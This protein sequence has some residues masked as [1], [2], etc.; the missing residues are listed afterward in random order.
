VHDFR[1][2][3][4]EGVMKTKPGLLG[5]R[6]AVWIGLADLGAYVSALLLASTG[7]LLK[8]GLPHGR[9]SGGVRHFG[10]P[11]E[12]WGLTR[13]GWGELHFWISMAFSAFIVLHL[14][15]HLPWIRIHFGR[16]HKPF[17]LTLAV[18]TLL[19]LL[20]LAGLLSL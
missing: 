17:T 13:S 2:S 6:R 7:L 1:V 12:V 19:A 8:F 9:G 10:V 18:L 11:P 3:S 16:L 5:I 20:P 15:L 4:V 14:F